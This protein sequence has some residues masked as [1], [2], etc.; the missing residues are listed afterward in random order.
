MV[1]GL[2]QITAPFKICEECVVSKQTRSQISKEKSWRAKDVLE[3]VHSDLCGPINP[4]SNGE[5]FSV[6][7]TPKNSAT[8]ATVA[9]ENE[10]TTQSVGCT[11]RRPAWMEDYEEAEFVSATACACQSIWLRRLLEELKFKQLGAT[12]IFCDNNSAIQLS[13]NPVLHGRSKH[14]DVK[15]Y[16]LRD[17][18]NNET[19]ELIYYRSEDQ[20]AD[21]FTKA[22]KMESFMKLRRLLGVF[23]IK[24]VN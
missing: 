15:F 6:A 10:E 20:I 8:S 17:L 24:D 18:S 12:K 9:V 11:I 21:I 3:L 2:P 13:K 5:K 16:F 7:C 23:T 4:T 1:T 19:I 22:L 14:I